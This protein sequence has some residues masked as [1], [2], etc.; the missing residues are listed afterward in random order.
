[1]PYISVMRIINSYLEDTTIKDEL[2]TYQELW[3]AKDY[4][5]AL[6]YLLNHPHLYS[7]ETWHY[8]LGSTYGE[9]KL[10]PQARYHLEQSY[11]LGKRDDKSAQSL[12]WIQKEIEADRYESLESWSDYLYRF[13]IYRPQ[14]FFT[15]LT[16]LFLALG[17]GFYAVKKISL[18]SMLA[19]V[20]L[21]FMISGLGYKISQ[22]KLIVAENTIQVYRGPSKIF[23]YQEVPAGVM[24]YL[25]PHE[26]YYKVIYPSS[27]EGWLLALPKNE[28]TQGSIWGL[29]KQ[30]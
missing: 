20:L 12:K 7:A 4:Q 19:F 6:D 29:T 17:F 18:K 16:L 13:L 24:L 1:M 2:K 10:L 8:N 21:A 14:Y 23:D 3:T 15:Q 22:N 5:K 27:I 28:L 30:K 25:V 11:Q 9:L 26:N